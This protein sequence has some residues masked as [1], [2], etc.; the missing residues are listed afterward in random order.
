MTGRTFLDFVSKRQALIFTM[1]TEF[2]G[3]HIKREIHV[4]RLLFSKSVYDE[5]KR[6]S[7]GS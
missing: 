3:K 6:T 4:I 2:K 5:F 7:V 1:T